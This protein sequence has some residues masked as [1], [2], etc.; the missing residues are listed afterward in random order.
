MAGEPSTASYPNQQIDPREKKYDWIL[1]Y[2]KAAYRDSTG[3][4]PGGFLNTGNFKMAETRMYAMGKQSVDK[5][6]KMFSPGNPTD[7]SWRAIDWTVPAFLCKFREIAI[8]K[9]I[10]KRFDLQA[11]AIDPI[12]KSE[13]DAF[14]NRMKVKIMM[15]EQAQREGSPLADS[16]LLQPQPGES[17]DMEQLEMQRDY[18]YKHQMAIEAENAYNLVF[19][20]NDIDEIMKTVYSNLYD[21]GIGGVT[22][23]IDE[24]GMVKLR[25]VNP[26]YLGLSYCEKPDFSDLI[27]WWEI[28][29]TYVADLA[30]YYT[31]EQMDEICKKAQ[32]KNGNPNQY[33]I[34]NGMFNKAWSRFKVNVLKIKFLSW[35][36]TVYKEEIDSRDN[37]RFGKSSYENKQFLSVDKLGE[38]READDY[39]YNG[40]QVEEECRGEATPKYINST[41]KVVYKASWVVDTD[42]M[43]DYGLQ[44]NQNRKYSS[45]WDTDLD[46]QLYSWNFYKMQFT[47]I[48][49]RLI[50]LE[51]KACMT[52]FNLQ[53]LSNKLIPYL[54][55]I[56]MNSIESA[57]FG[58]G[59]KKMKPGELVDFIFSN[60]IVPWRA[61]DLLSRNPNFKPVTIEATGQ[62]GA[63]EQL[64]NDLAN[65]LDM[66]R[67]ISGLNELTDASTPNAKTLVPV[68]QAAVESTN[69]AMYLVSDAGK[70]VLR[71]A[72]DAI[73]QKVQIAVGLGKVSGYAK[74]LGS[75]TVKFFEINPN[76]SL[77]E[78]GIFIDDAP[79]D[80]QREALW[81]D[82]NI[83][84]SQGLLTVGDKAYVM[85]VRNLKEAYQVLDYKIKKRREEA[86]QFEMQKIQQQNEGAAEAAERAEMAKQQTLAI[87]HQFDMEKLSA[88]GQWTFITEQMKKQ[89]D[90]NS[91]V[92]QSEGKVVANQVVAE[93]KVISQQIAAGA[94]QVG[95][96]IDA[97]AH[98]L[99]KKID[100][101]NKPKPT[102]KK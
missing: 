71:R 57:G 66:M 72:A 45:W 34:T 19:Q 17:E 1:Q 87:M 16:P 95:K 3:Y 94:S 20:Q 60:Y 58:K 47:G 83:K 64:Y 44:E 46:I 74:A 18:G 39:S 35:N 42:Y 32:G 28:I 50:P 23:S 7:D 49:E 76:I 81:N 65:T 63:F 2:T 52:W 68:A 13:E 5:Y 90:E 36:D 89:S 54:I 11:F 85:T 70:S 61:N 8:S 43:H 79:T 26:E 40:S 93:A 102:S 51:D 101:K 37:M 33:A 29:P 80:A 53:N 22:P 31:K 14:F 59:G 84:E 91:A 6:K 25:A 100:A 41:R 15:R 10:Q 38:L 21:W 12:A 92:I 24:N 77:H 99:G 55:N 9:L 78:L 30:P 62:L 96:E 98:L 97:T 88:Q 82:V 4:M 56:E 73:V 86:Q 27:H 69:N 67:Q 48:T 75:N